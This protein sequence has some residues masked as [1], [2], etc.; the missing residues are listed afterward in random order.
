MSLF[1]RV[2]EYVKTVPRGKV[3]TYGQVAAAIGG[4]VFTESCAVDGAGTVECVTP[5]FEHYQEKEMA[6]GNYAVV[7]YII[8]GKYVCYAFSFTGGAL[9]EWFINNLAGDA[10]EQARAQ[11]QDVHTYLESGWKG[12]PTGILVL[13]HFA[14]AA[15]PYM[16]PGSRGAI[17]GLNMAH[18]QRDLYLAVM[19]GVCY[20]MR[21]NVDRLR[22]AGVTI[23]SLRATGGG[24]KSRT[25]LQEGFLDKSSLREGTL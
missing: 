17:V 2:Y 5:V 3:V 12:E 13:P 6:A 25:A 21:L 4:G 14:G 8:P 16:D 23:N 15:T 22:Q 11:G 7:P 18:T 19:E 24:A 10:T 1:E 20:E 9:I